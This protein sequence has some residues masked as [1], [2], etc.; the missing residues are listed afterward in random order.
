MEN[1]TS[2]LLDGFA[3]ALSLASIALNAATIQSIDKIKKANAVSVSVS[4]MWETELASRRTQESVLRELP[5]I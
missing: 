4:E 3:I 5:S 1:K 2:R